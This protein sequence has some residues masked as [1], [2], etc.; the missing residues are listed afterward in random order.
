VSAVIGHI[1][2]LPTDRIISDANNLT[3]PLLQIFNLFKFREK[4]FVVGGI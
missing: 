3:F 2:S 1:V 4:T